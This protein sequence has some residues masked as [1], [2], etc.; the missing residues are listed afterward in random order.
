MKKLIEAATQDCMGI[1]QVDPDL[2]VKQVVGECVLAILATDTRDI[3][4][5]TWDRDQVASI[6]GRVVDNVRNHFE[7]QYA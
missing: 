3:V 1:K 6:I 5:T 7:E 4:Y 2:L